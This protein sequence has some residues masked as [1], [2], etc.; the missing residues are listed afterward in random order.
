MPTLLCPTD[1]P[2]GCRLERKSSKVLRIR[3]ETKITTMLIK[4]EEA[5]GA[6]SWSKDLR[7]NIATYEKSLEI[8]LW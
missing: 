1:A 2:S 8:N 5:F 7:E 6:F 3:R 4:V